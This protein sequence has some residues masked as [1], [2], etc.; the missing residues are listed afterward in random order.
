MA[1]RILRNMKYE[2]YFVYFDAWFSA[3]LRTTL[4][5]RRKW[6]SGKEGLS[7]LLFNVELQVTNIFEQIEQRKWYAIS[8]QIGTVKIFYKVSN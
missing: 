7:W 1:L 8:F 4:R 3:H 2:V 5:S 6:D